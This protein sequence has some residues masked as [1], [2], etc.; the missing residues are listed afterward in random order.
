[1]FNCLQNVIKP[2][3][4]SWAASGLTGWRYCCLSPPFISLSHLWHRWSPTSLEME[5]E[6]HTRLC[7]PSSP[8]LSILHFLPLLH[9]QHFCPSSDSSE[10]FQLPS[11]WSSCHQYSCHQIHPPYLCQAQHL[12]TFL[13]CILYSS[14]TKLLVLAVPFSFLP[15]C[16]SLEHFSLA[17]TFSNSNSSLRNQLRCD[18]L[19]KAILFCSL[20]FHHILCTL[21]LLYFLRGSISSLLGTFWLT[22]S[23][24]FILLLELLKHPDAKQGRKVEGNQTAYSYFLLIST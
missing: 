4:L 3:M 8:P 16:S 22:G 10:L 19:Q 23:S 13:V 1:M 21:L 11:I 24:M 15:P 20:C 9:T 14:N 7:S 12:P 2:R 5:L 6:Y 17:P 18:F